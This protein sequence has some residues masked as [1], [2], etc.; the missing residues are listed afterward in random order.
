MK[1]GPFLDTSNK[2]KLR[3]L[4]S[5]SSHIRHNGLLVATS[6]LVV[7]MKTETLVE[8][9]TSILEQNERRLKMEWRIKQFENFMTSEGYHNIRFPELKSN[10]NGLGLEYTIEPIRD[11]EGRPHKKISEMYEYYLIRVR[12]LRWNDFLDIDSIKQYEDSPICEGEPYYCQFMDGEWHMSRESFGDWHRF[13]MSCKT[14]MCES[15]QSANHFMGHSQE[16]TDMEKVCELYITDEGTELIGGGGCTVYRIFKD[17]KG[18]L[19]VQV[20]DS[21]LK[22]LYLTNERNDW[23]TDKWFLVIESIR[24]YAYGKTLYNLRGTIE[25]KLAE[26]NVVIPKRH[27]SEVSYV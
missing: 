3:Y 12:P 4:R 6:F 13:Y 18:N 9:S 14:G 7:G 2:S 17:S 1:F 8:K 5:L 20:H 27:W 10:I 22:K 23:T 15:G 21:P 25:K 11:S 24:G 19:F 26:L 16:P